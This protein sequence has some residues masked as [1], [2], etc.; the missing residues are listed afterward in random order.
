MGIGGCWYVPTHFFPVYIS[1]KAFTK[2]S[3]FYTPVGPFLGILL[4]CFHMRGHTKSAFQPV[5][6]QFHQ[7][8][9]DYNYQYQVLAMLQLEC[10]AITKNL[11]IHSHQQM[12]CGLQCVCNPTV[13]VNKFTVT[14]GSTV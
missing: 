11:S 12:F 5:S 2:W 4:L 1:V 3:C 10:I 7:S 6:S 9:N 13:G 14:V 8:Y